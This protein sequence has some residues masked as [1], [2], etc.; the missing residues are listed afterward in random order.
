MQVA[1]KD[2]LVNPLFYLKIIFL[3]SYI[4][5]YLIGAITISQGDSIHVP[6]SPQ[7]YKYIGYKVN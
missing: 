6:K 1:K 7:G 3:H 4:V 5:K 2:L